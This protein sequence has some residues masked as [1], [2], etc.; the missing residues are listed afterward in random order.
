MFPDDAG[1]KTGLGTAASSPGPDRVYPIS[2]WTPPSQELKPLS[3][4]E[5]T[6]VWYSLSRKIHILSTSF[7]K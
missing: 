3:P 6:N 1:A 7:Y 4:K 5:I 2:A